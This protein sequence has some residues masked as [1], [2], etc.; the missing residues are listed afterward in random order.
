[1]KH[2]QADQSLDRRLEEL[3]R[4]G[5]RDG[6]T[7]QVLTGL[8]DRVAASSASPARLAWIGAAALVLVAL[9]A[10]GVVY[11]QQ[12]AADLAYRRQVKE[13]RSRYEQLLDEVVSIR[14]E[15]VTP[16]TR[17]YLGGDESL[18]LMLDLNRLPTQAPNGQGDRQQIRPANWE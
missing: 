5:A 13:L 14:Q 17:L 18:D 8:D 15:A 10:L 3:P 7:Q 4:I 9:L 2:R 16:E 6:F 1:M 12:R 11:Q